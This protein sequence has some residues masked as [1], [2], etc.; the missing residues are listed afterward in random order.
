MSNRRQEPPPWSW[1]SDSQQQDRARVDQDPFNF[2]PS[3]EG[4]VYAAS[5]AVQSTHHEDD[6]MSKVSTYSYRSDRDA[7]RFVKE[8]D[9]RVGFFNSFH[10]E[11]RLIVYLFL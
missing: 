10:T 9:G 11:G 4:S 3:E 7:S 5:M 2:A 1:N 8:V 6:A